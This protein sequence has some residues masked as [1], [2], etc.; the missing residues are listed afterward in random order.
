MVHFFKDTPA[1]YDIFSIL[2]LFHF[3]VL[4]LLVQLLCWAAAADGGWWDWVSVGPMGFIFL[5]PFAETQAGIGNAHSEFHICTRG[6]DRTGWVSWTWHM[7]WVELSKDM[8]WLSNFLLPSIYSHEEGSEWEDAG[9]GRRT[10]TTPLP[11]AMVVLLQSLSTSRPHPVSMS[12]I[13]CTMTGLIWWP[14]V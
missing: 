11:R 10:Q 9:G 14:G 6:R 1:C 3:L 7:G 12:P 5:I 2:V 8:I 13:R 4:I